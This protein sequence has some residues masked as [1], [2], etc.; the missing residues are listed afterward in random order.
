MSF[1]ILYFLLKFKNQ[2]TDNID[3]IIN[4]GDLQKQFFIPF[5]KH[6]SSFQK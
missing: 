3:D 2:R 6:L 1:L 5:Q 4:N